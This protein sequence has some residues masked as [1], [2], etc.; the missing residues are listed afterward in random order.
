MIAVDNQKLLIKPTHFIISYE[1]ITSY[2][3]LSKARRIP[4]S[5]RTPAKTCPDHSMKKAVL[6][7]NSM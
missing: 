1:V 5:S 2:L 4:N 3:R 6:G 7:Y